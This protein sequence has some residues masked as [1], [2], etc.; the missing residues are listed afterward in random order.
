VAVA[1]R[2]FSSNFFQPFEPD[3][4]IA[5]CEVLCRRQALPRGAGHVD[6]PLASC[7]H[8]QRDRQHPALPFGVK[9]RSIG[10]R[11]DRAE[12]LHAAEILCAVHFDSQVR[13]GDF[14]KP[15]PIIESRVTRSASDRPR[16]PHRDRDTRPRS[17]G[18]YEFYFFLHVQ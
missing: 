15:V 17:T 8:R 5:A 13:S 11:L 3:F 2:A 18:T 16:F 7:A 10:A 4:E 9:R 12:R 6:V 1:K 14:G